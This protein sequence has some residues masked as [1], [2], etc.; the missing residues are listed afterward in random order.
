MQADGVNEVQTVSSKCWVSIGS[1]G[2]WVPDRGPNGGVFEMLVFNRLGGGRG[3]DGVWA[4]FSK[5]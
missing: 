4:G 2:G 1:A 3:P 5:Y